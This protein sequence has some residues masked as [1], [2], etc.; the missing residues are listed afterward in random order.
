MAAPKTQ[1]EFVSEGMVYSH[2]FWSFIIANDVENRN[3]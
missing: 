2:I 3:K 1:T